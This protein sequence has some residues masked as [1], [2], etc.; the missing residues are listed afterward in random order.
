MSP[1]IWIPNSSYS[2][3]ARLPRVLLRQRLMNSCEQMRAST[4]GGTLRARTYFF[5]SGNRLPFV[6]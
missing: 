5:F 3:W 2:N 1:V 6:L 4:S